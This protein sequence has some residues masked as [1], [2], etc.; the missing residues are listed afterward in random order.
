MKP[1]PDAGHAPSTG[2]RASHYDTVIVGAGQAGLSVGYHLARLGRQFVILDEHERVGDCWR[3]RY[4]SLRLYSPAR[5]DGLP[6]MPFPAPP[7]SFPSGRQMA[8]YLES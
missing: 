6:G 8:D 3:E 7:H 2:D 4:D 5:Y 1:Q